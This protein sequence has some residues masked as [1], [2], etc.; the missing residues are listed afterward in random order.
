MVKRVDSDSTKTPCKDSRPVSLDDLRV[1]LSD[2]AE[3]TK[4]WPFTA[5]FCQVFLLI[6]A[7][8]NTDS[9]SLLLTLLFFTEI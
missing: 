4:K 8:A 5:P 6:S 3:M 9:P 2:D 7:V 1:N